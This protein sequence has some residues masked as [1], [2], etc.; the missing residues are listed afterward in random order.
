MVALGHRLSALKVARTRTPGL[1]A[2]GNGLYLQVTSPSARSWIFRYHRNG[3]SREMG[4]GSLN[5]VSLAAARQ[6]AA[7]CRAQL[8][9]GLDPIAAR[10]SERTQRSIETARGV[11]FATRTS[12]NGGTCSALSP[13]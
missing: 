5:A 8:A 12:S 13:H 2:D 1:F 3:K 11:S 6:K 7:A 4:L 10:T 9:D